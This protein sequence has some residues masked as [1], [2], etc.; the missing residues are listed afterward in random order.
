M[1]ASESFR[2]DLGPNPA[3][4]QTHDRID[5]S[6][7]SRRAPSSLRRRTGCPHLNS[8]AVATVLDSD[9]FRKTCGRFATGI[10]IAT[11]TSSDGR[12]FGLT[13]NSFTSVSAAPPLVLICVDYRSTVL[14]HFRASS[15]YCVN[16]LGE[17]QR[18]LS[19]RFSQ[20]I[21][22]RFIGLG[23]ERG[24]SGAPVLDGC[25]ANLECSVVQT[26]E[27]GDHAH[28]IAEVIHAR[29]R[30]GKPLLYFA[31]DYCELRD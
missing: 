5:F 7:L 1:P 12:P 10:A 19:V 4:Q 30:E 15:W 9:V 2:R 17:D 27:A 28:F 3:G 13:V 25:L 22:D 31:S 26:V 23:W 8:M 29:C 24:A 18:D 6:R 14:T 21:P 16:V 20:R 11:V